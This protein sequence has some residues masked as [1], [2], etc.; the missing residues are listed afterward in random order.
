[1]ELDDGLSDASC[2]KGMR[3]LFLSA[4]NLLTGA[5]SLSDQQ[6]S[7]DTAEVDGAADSRLHMD[8]HGAIATTSFPVAEINRGDAEYLVIGKV[9]PILCQDL[10]YEDV[11][12]IGEYLLTRSVCKYHE[13]FFRIRI[14]AMALLNDELT[15]A[16]EDGHS[17]MPCPAV[18]SV[19]GQD[20]CL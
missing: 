10:A 11:W 14:R 3:K 15:P 2:S 16:G 13:A 19:T 12:L 5:A 20:N 17:H 9:F 18:S 8:L 1:M 7:L 6:M 4:D